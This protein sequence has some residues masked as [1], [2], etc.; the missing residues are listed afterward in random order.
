M[1]QL[2]RNVF[3]LPSLA[4]KRHVSLFCTIT[5]Y[6]EIVIKNYGT[7]RRRAPGCLGAL[8]LEN[9]EDSWT[10]KIHFPWRKGTPPPH[11]N[12]ARMLFYIARAAF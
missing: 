1:R 12:L 9:V 3:L 11:S 8:P 10:Y 2:G 4:E 7:F 5:R 6:V